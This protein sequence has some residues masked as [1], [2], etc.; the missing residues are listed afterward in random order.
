MLEDLLK[1]RKNL[2]RLI[3]SVE[4]PFVFTSKSDNFDKIYNSPGLKSSYV[5]S[6]IT[7]QMHLS[8]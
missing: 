6:I 1:L 7:N 5:N 3:E 8:E 4:N 2:K